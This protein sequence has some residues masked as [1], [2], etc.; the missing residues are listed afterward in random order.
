[1][2]VPSML[3]LFVKQDADRQARARAF[4]APRHLARQVGRGPRRP[5]ITV[6]GADLPP[7][8]VVNAESRTLH[9]RY[10]PGT[11]LE[12]TGRGA[13]AKSLLI[14]VAISGGLL[15]DQ[16]LPFWGQVLTNVAVWALFLHWL[17]AA[18]SRERVTL[19]VCVFYATLG[20][21]FLA[22]AWGLYEYRLGNVPLF[23][24]PGHALLFALG[25]LL[26]AR[27]REWIV[28]FIP[29]AVAPFVCVL[30]L[31]DADTFGAL[32]FALFVLCLRVGRAPR[33]YAVMFV[34]ALAME[35]YGTWLGN[36]TWSRTVPWLGLS[37][38]NPPLAAGVFYCVLDLL[39]MATVARR[40]SLA[41]P[42]LLS[43][44]DREPHVT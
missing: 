28:W 38:L 10:D 40:G 17:R 11:L 14:V 32:L 7:I 5:A 27:A 39:V 23:V 3:R 25:A 9:H 26:A 1:M 36:W 41:P 42:A 16:T 2:A 31:W 8:I 6:E 18:G 4:T 34:L 29:A 21:I 15:L 24:P 30:A 20:E 19:T 35:L 12:R 43:A 33:L 37:T 44:A 22:L 13:A